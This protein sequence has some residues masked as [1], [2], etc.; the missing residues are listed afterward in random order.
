MRS[1]AE[2]QH[3]Q[4]QFLRRNND[5][6]R[7]RQQLQSPAVV[8]NT[9]FLRDHSIILSKHGNVCHR[10]Q[11]VFIPRSV[12]NNIIPDIIQHCCFEHCFFE[13]RRFKQFVRQ[14]CIFLASVFQQ[15]TRNK[16]VF[17]WLIFQQHIPTTIRDPG[18]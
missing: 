18:G 4:Q 3:Q 13:H 9:V 14:Q 2:Q 1:P 11:R 10:N 8:D 5:K 12:H 15:C 6:Q 7:W 17:W 16:R